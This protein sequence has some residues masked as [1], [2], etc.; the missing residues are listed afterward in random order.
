M[1]NFHQF[2]GNSLVP[3]LNL[4]YKAN[5]LSNCVSYYGTSLTDASICYTINGNNLL[6][7]Q[8]V[9]IGPTSLL[10]GVSYTGNNYTYGNI[11]LNILQTTYPNQTYTEFQQDIKDLNWTNQNYQTAYKTLIKNHGN[12]TVL[13]NDLDR[14]MDEI[15][16]SSKS[17]SSLSLN[18]SVY[19]T[20]FWTVLATS[21]LYFLFIHL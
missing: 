3:L 6:N 8:N 17:D 2:Y 1:T 20:L 4:N 18:N 16:N 21:L 15:Y 5:L 13:R 11:H 7:N 9:R 10:D 14:K 12:V 19:T